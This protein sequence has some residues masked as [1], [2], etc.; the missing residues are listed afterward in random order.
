[1]R[2][3]LVPGNNSLSHVAR[4]LAIRG[5]LLARGHEVHLAVAREHA[6]FLRR[7]GCPHHLLPDVQECDHSPFP[8][9]RWFQSADRL[10]RCIRAEADLVARLAP[11]RVL[12][13]FRFTSRA[14]A[15]LAGVA[16]DSLI[17]GCMHPCCGQ[18]LGFAGDE[19]QAE[20]QRQNLAAFF[21]YAAARASRA[22]ERFD[23]PPVADLRELL[24]GERTFLWDCPEFLELSDGPGLVHVGPIDISECFARRNGAR[25]S[26]ERPL[27]LLSFGTGIA[28][29][30]VLGRLA[31]VLAQDGFEVLIA[32]GGQNHL[33]R[34]GR[35]ERHIAVHRLLPL[36]RCLRDAALLVCH[37]G[38]GTI[39]EA[40]SCGV[41]VLVMPFQPEQAHNGVCLQRMGCGRLLIPPTPFLGNAEVYVEAFRRLTDARIRAAV[42]GLLDDPRAAAQLRGAQTAI[43]R[44]RGAETLAA[45]LEEEA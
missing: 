20:L 11:Q 43:S 12:G 35:G 31:R 27:A 16:Y 38:Q 3:L 29:P 7:H 33:P 26:G 15:R 13:V 1:M 22:L 4:C 44:Y 36:R 18:V 24:L 41:P 6:A 42:R 19:P 25:A 9:F 2:F 23:L 39:F 45:L 8:T 32:G 21:R 34:F 40:L 30:D 17:C 28:M 37:G 5:R 10:A 14:A